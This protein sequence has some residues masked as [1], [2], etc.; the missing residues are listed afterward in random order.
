MSRTRQS[1]FPRKPRRGGR[2]YGVA[3]GYRW[4]DGGGGGVWLW[5]QRWSRWQSPPQSPQ[6]RRA[7]GRLRGHDE[8][9]FTC[10]CRRAAR[11][12]PSSPRITK[13][14]WP[15]T[16]SRH[17]RPTHPPPGIRCK[18]VVYKCV[19]ACL[20]VCVYVSVCVCMCVY[21]YVCVHQQH[22]RRTFLKNTLP[23]VQLL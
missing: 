14:G 13:T 4:P 23:R 6:P 19:Y 5:Q 2:Y 12:A 3:D 22:D 9:R 21:V 8:S 1:P 10:C 16:A 20:C 18:P 15:Y 17:T 11:L 7:D